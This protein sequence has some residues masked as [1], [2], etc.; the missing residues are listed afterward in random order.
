MPSPATRSRTAHHPFGVVLVG[1]DD[2]ILMRQGNTDTVHRRLRKQFKLH[3]SPRS[4]HEAQASRT[5]C[6]T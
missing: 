5:T 6:K 2:A 4:S 3:H 1:P